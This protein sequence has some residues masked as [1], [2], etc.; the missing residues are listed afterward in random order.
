VD[1]KTDSRVVRLEGWEGCGHKDRQQS[2][3][4]GGMWRLWTQRQWLSTFSDSRAGKLEV[5]FPMTGTLSY[6]VQ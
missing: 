6:N 3:E 2:R 4:A 5:G 1:T